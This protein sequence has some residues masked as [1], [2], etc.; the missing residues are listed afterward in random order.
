MTES[1]AAQS[2]CSQCRLAD[3]NAHQSDSPALT[4]CTM[5]RRRIIIAGL[6]VLILGSVLL[7]YL[8][9][10]HPIVLKSITGSARI[11]P[12]AL[13][14]S[15]KID[16]VTQSAARCF[17]I[18]SHF[19]GEPADE[20]VLWLPASSDVY[21]RDILLIDRANNQVGRPN[22][23]NEDYDLLWNR[24]LFQSE[25]G[26]RYVSFTSAKSY[27][28]DPELEFTDKSLRFSVPDVSSELQGQRFE[29][30][31]R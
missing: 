22:T 5:K 25:S 21:G 31:L 8:F 10:S 2:P 18:K 6:T 4:P 19:N 29:I 16:G 17:Q 7:V 1:M 12:S 14:A 30:L 20:F 15:I 24:F 3:L 13:N 9:E 27:A 28:Q 11:L 26:S 23:T